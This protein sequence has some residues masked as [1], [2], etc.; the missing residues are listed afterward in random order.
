MT[1]IKLRQTL[2][3]IWTNYHVYCYIET[4]RSSGAYISEDKLNDDYFWEKIA[5]YLEKNK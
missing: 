5:R 4:L 1:N 3:D 2:T